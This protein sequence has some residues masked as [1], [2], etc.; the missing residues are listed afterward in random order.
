MQQ[1]SNCPVAIRGLSYDWTAM[2]NLVDSMVPTGNTNQPIGLVWG[3]QSLVGGGPLTAPAMDSNYKYEQII[4][5]LS[6]GLNT[7]NRWSTRQSEV[8]ARMVDSDGAGT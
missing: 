6:D 4:I 2:N 5:L 8:D 3:W 7:E 1:Y